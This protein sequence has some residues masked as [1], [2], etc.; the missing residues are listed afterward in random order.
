MKTTKEHGKTKNTTHRKKGE[1]G[2][3][4]EKT[5]VIFVLVGYVAC[6]GLFCEKKQFPGRVRCPQFFFH[7]VFFKK[8]FVWHQNH[9]FRFKKSTRRSAVNFCIEQL[10]LCSKLVWNR[11]SYDQHIFNIKIRLLSM[12]TSK[13]SLTQAK[14]SMTKSKLCMTKSK[15]SVWIFIFFSFSEVSFSYSKTVYSTKKLQRYLV[16]NRIF[17]KN[18]LWKNYFPFSF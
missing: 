16:K 4:S 17:I 18:F 5:K 7:D 2:N 10:F 14:F 8:W 9:I 1:I 11:T 13:F 6:R 3:T 15:L 12:S